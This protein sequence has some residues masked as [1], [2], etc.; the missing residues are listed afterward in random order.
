MR[1]RNKECVFVKIDKSN[2]L[3]KLQGKKLDKLSITRLFSEGFKLRLVSNMGQNRRDIFHAVIIALL[4][5]IVL[6]GCGHKTG[7]VYVPDSQ[8]SGHK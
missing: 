5:C 8:K 6:M 7:V 1:K 4:C 3:L 2:G